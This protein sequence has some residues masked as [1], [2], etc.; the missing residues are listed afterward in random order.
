MSFQLPFRDSGQ[1]ISLEDPVPEDFQ[2]PFRDSPAG[3]KTP[4]Q[5]KTFQLPFRDSDKIA[6]DILFD[7][8]FLSTPFPG[9]DV[10]EI[11]SSGDRIAFNSL[12]GIRAYPDDIIAPAQFYLSTPFPG[13][14]MYLALP[15]SLRPP[16][17]QLPF[18]DS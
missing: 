9:F 4:Q 10:D 8:E 7:E 12:S 3:N 14:R 17:F 16:S 1:S 2:L 13:F 18:R 6:Y 11:I 15:W 5:K